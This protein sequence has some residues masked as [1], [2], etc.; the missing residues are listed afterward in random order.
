MSIVSNGAS[1][2][3]R[4]AAYQ[5]NICPTLSRD[6]DREGRPVRAFYQDV[7]STLNSERRQPPV[8]T[9]QSTLAQPYYTSQGCD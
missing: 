2:A 4:R 5:T 6:G 8:S 7:V 1:A 9:H 3:K